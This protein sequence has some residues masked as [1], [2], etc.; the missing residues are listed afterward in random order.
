[1]SFFSAHEMPVFPPAPWM[2]RL[3][4][5]PGAARLL[6]RM[7]RG[8]TR[9][10]MDPVRALRAELGLPSR[11]DPLYEGQHS[12]HLV[13]ALF[14]RTLG[15]PQPDWPARVRI[16]GPVFYNGPAADT[17]PDELDRFLQSGEPPIVFTLGSSAVSAAGA[18]YEHSAAAARTLGVRAVLLTGAH[19]GNRPAQHAGNDILVVDH[20]PHAALLPRAAITVHQGGVG[21]LQQALRAG[22]PMLVT[23]FAHDQP[24]NAYRATRLGVARVLVPSRYTARRA[25]IELQTLLEDERYATRAREVGALVAA[26][27]GATAACD[28]IEGLFDGAGSRPP[29][30]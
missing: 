15:A 9:R 20:A 5:I 6:V 22:V 18:F 21:T 11:G 10:W 7:V 25:A 19:E 8:V 16:T 30:A 2:K 23:P 14:S 17:L 27:D 3:E 4:Q 12:P 29:P 28:A 26:E 13:L 24:D 1:M